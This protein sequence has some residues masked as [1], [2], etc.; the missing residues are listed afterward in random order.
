MRLENCA[1][2]TK[3]RIDPAVSASEDHTLKVWDLPR[4]ADL[5]TA[6]LATADLPTAAV[7]TLRGHTDRINAV[8]VEGDGRLAVSAS[9]D[10]TLKLWPLAP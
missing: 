10:G 4:A 5:A 2:Y 8:G 3:F 7:R 9:D 1:S 6:D